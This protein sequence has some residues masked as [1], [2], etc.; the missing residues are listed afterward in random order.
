MNSMRLLSIKK[1]P[2]IFSRLKS[3]ALFRD[4]F[5][6]VFG[7]A[8]G[9]GLSLVAGILVARFLGSDTFGE[10][11][12]VKDTLV[13]IAIFSSFGLGYTATKFI[14]ENPIKSQIVHRI[15]MFITFIFSAFIAMLLFV[16]S[17]Y[18]AVW[19]EAKHLGVIIRWSSIAI[20][21]NAISTTLMG[22]LAGFKSYKTIALNN[23]IVGIITFVI[24]VPLSYFFYLKGAIIALIFSYLCNSVFNYISIR[25]HLVAYRVD[26]TLDGNVAIKE[27]IKFSFPVALQESLYSLTHWCGTWLLIKYAGYEQL[28]IYSVAV[29]WG[30]VVLYI[31]GALRNVALSYLS[32]TNSDLQANSKLLKQLLGI[33]FAT[34][35]LPFLVIACLSQSIC[36]WYGTTYLGLRIVLIVVVFSSIISSLTNV[37]TQELMAFNKNWFLFVGRLIRDIGALIIAFCM[38]H[39]W[40]KG[41]LCFAIAILATQSVYLAML[42]LEHRGYVKNLKK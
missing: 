10:Y 40:G 41:A 18:V 3:S 2:N 39:F 22:E 5:W 35:F 34:T 31:P 21:F 26:C 20:I 29:Q 42:C 24:T 17:D 37:L 33:N 1:L 28:G 19:I 8:L 30:A 27:I 25:K 7:N 16:F 6:A 9:R 4:S 36:S 14:A 11:G 23:T 38:I 32:T 13:M 15:C 12:I